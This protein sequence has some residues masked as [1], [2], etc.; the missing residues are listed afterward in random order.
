MVT[1]VICL[2]ESSSFQNAFQT[3]D[4]VNKTVRNL[5]LVYYFWTLHFLMEGEN[6]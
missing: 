1:H 3:H 6:E 2:T 5:V 4:M